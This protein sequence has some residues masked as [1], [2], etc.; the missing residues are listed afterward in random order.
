MSR[1]HSHSNSRS[2]SRSRRR[3]PEDERRRGHSRSRSHSSRSRRRS[4]SRSRS[5]R[6]DYGSRKRLFTPDRNS[7]PSRSE[8]SHVAPPPPATPAQVSQIFQTLLSSALQ[9]SPGSASVATPSLQQDRQMLKGNMPPDLK[10]RL[11]CMPF[12]HICLCSLIAQLYL[13]E[14]VQNIATR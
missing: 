8:H 14:F 10:F 11:F 9:N 12:F 3:G 7:S 13:F 5:R 6:R 1:S 2:R 4:R